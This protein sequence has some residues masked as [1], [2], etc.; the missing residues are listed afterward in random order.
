MARP[1][2]PRRDSD[3]APR[4]WPALALL[5]TLA[6]VVRLPFWLEALR[7]PIDG[8]TAIV[9]LMAQHGLAS[10]TFWGQ[11]YGS[12]LDAWLAAPFVALLGPTPL[13][14]RL[15][16]FLLS[17]TLV[18]LG[19]ALA[20][21]LHPAAAAPA[22]FLLACPP[23][24]L[25]LLSALP[26]PVYPVTLPLL[27]LLLLGATATRKRRRGVWGRAA[28]RGPP[29][30]LTPADV[31]QGLAD[32]APLAV[33]TL[34]LWGLAAGLALWTHLVA[35]A[36]VVPALAYLAWSARRSRAGLARVLLA[37]LPAL[38]LA[39]AP[40]WTRLAWDPSATA[41]VS[42]GD[43]GGATWSHL[44]A[45]LPRMHEPLLGLLGAHT[46]T[47]ADDP[48][49][50]VGLPVGGAVALALLY[51]VGLLRAAQVARRARRGASRA[52]LRAA[53]VAA[54]LGAALA[55][56]VL[57]FPWPLR[58]GPETIRFLTPAYLPLA[59]L[60][61][62]APAAEGHRRGAW[63]LVLTLGLLHLVPAT[64]LL[65]A[66]RAAGPA[67]LLPDCRPV[68]R[69]LD[70]RGLRRAWASYDTA[71]CLTYLSGERVIASQPWNE[72][73]P[74]AALR[75][76]DEVRFAR[77]V[78]WVLVPGADFDLPRPE[79]FERDL[80]ASGGAFRRTPVGQAFVYDRFVPPWPA[81]G[82]APRGTG[83]AGDGD[84]TT[85]VVEP[86]RGPTMLR[87]DAPARLAA[88]T[89]AS[90][91]EPPGL[92]AGLALDVSADGVVFERVARLRAGLGGATAIVWANGQPMAREGL[93]VVSLPLHG[94]TVVAL[95]LTPAP[96]QGP[97]SLA[98]VLLHAPAPPAAW[99]DDAARAAATWSER[100]QRLQA[101]ARPCDAGWQFRVWLA[102]R[103]SR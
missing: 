40:W 85:R 91:L 19:W 75:Y 73:F 92:P 24:Y 77:D 11:P 31:G 95:R 84:L 55:L 82:R 34:L 38:V 10:A 25:L 59:V 57:A 86:G 50:H 44:R 56:T 89:L 93:E 46:P 9:G 69:L 29:D 15:P 63:V 76:R 3:Q 43:A 5:V 20:R 33:R 87:L 26:P 54:L 45:L 41:V 103:A 64:R 66:W 49:N 74:G 14:V 71:W 61:A 13:A 52:G 94:R 7:L 39:S 97:W 48:L 67:E 101:G 6:A 37:T 72:R 2:A 21:R 62:W 16:C 1:Q 51:A 23:A 47:T 88:V 28:K 102:S 96:E 70:E 36:V 90:G 81:E 12:P 30:E 32:D 27:G 35:L 58:A 8:D 42:L 99:P 4:A 22:A 17:L 98:E 68:L 65:A 83:A 53:G 18:P 100:R 60:V 79:R 78:A 80:R